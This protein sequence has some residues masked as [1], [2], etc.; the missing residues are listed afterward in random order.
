[1]PTRTLSVRGLTEGAILSALVALFTL[2]AQYFPPIAVLSSLVTPLPLSMLVVRHGMR[3]GV[4]GTLVATAIAAIIGGPLAALAIV[5]TF[6][7]QGL[8]FGTMIRQQRSAST[9]LLV[10]SI[11]CTLSVLLNAVRTLVLSGFNPFGVMIEGMA[12]SQ[13]EAMRLYARFGLNEA[14]IE[15]AAGPMR[16]ALALMPRLIPLLVVIAG[17]TSAY[18]NFEVTRFVFRRLR[19]TVPALPPL[20]WWRIPMPV[21][22]AL[23]VGIGLLW[24]A[25][26][27]PVPF[28]VP[29]E[30][31]R[32]LPPDD[33]SA[34]V[35][36]VVS[37]Y[38]A[39][40]TAGLNLTLLMQMLFSIMGLLAAW[41][42]LE[43]YGAPRWLRWAAILFVFSSPQLN[44]AVFLLGLA[45][46]AFD[47]RRRWRTARAAEVSA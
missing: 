31:I 37:R 12:Q 26:A 1:M 36:R 22:W 21:L 45:D 47:L 10:G 42:L 28:N 25:Q 16:Q 39:I 4:L 33:M 27:A 6:A 46:V 24:F 44:I 7:P 23:P 9:I 2:A 19:Y 35:Y 20:S 34:V 41:V 40:E 17:I 43:R 5:L 13:E 30:T 11:V 18:I 15:Q 3:V 38:P 14:T 32:M 29:G 8:V